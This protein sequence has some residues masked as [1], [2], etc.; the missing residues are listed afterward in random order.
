MTLVERIPFSPIQ[1]EGSV[2]FVR[3]TI[4]PTPYSYPVLRIC[5]QMTLLV[6]LDLTNTEDALRFS[7]S[8]V[9]L[10]DA[11]MSKV[12]ISTLPSVTSKV[13]GT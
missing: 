13:E 12:G 11:R 4:G 7:E 10:D 2:L 3:L 1:S 9:A 6:H 5:A 8:G